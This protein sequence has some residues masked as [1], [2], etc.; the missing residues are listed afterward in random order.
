MA[1]PVVEDLSGLTHS[2]VRLGFLDGPCVRYAEKV[3]GYRPF[4]DFSCSATLPAHAT[5]LGKA[6]LAFSPPDA[7]EHVIRHG[8]RRYTPA[9]I[10]SAAALRHTL[11]VSKLRGMAVAHG[12][13]VAEQ[14]TVAA[15]VF[16]HGG[17]VLA[18]LELRLHETRGD[19]A[20]LAPPLVIA[21][22]ALSRELGR[23]APSPVPSQ[24]LEPDGAAT[25]EP[26]A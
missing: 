6:V 18:A 11:K 21:A 23:A 20:R 22:R 1:T 13:L 26:R 3:H 9:T 25:R 5:A 2:D 15:P 19:L 12:E 16:G 7:V 4:S 8:L 17:E 24:S 10:T 14:A